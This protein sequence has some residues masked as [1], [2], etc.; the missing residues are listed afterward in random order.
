MS[1]VLA[2]APTIATNA[3]IQK[4]MR[5]L[6]LKDVTNVV[7]AKAKTPPKA[8]Q[9]DVIVT[10]GYCIGGLVISVIYIC[11]CYFSHCR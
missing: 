3:P 8:L 2:T 1:L 7:T 10:A 4:A 11:R 6:K 5:Q 9:I